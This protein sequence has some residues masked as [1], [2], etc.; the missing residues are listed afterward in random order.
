M[1]PLLIVVIL[2]ILGKVSFAQSVYEVK[3]SP[4]NTDSSSL[5]IVMQGDGT[6][7]IRS[8]K[9]FVLANNVAELSLQQFLPISNPDLPDDSLLYFKPTAPIRVSN[10]NS[11]LSNDLLLCF[12]TDGV[13]LPYPIGIITDSEILKKLNSDEMV[14]RIKID[15]FTSVNNID[16]KEPKPELFLKYF[17]PTDNFFVQLF[18]NNSK[19]IT[20]QQQ[21]TNLFLL[22]VAN[23]NDK[24]I[25]VSAA[26]DMN[27]Y[28]N[29]FKQLTSFLGIKFTPIT[30]S[31]SEYNKQNLIN[32]INNKLTP[33]AQDIVIFYFTGHG[34]RLPRDNRRYPY[35]DLRPNMKSSYMTESL[36]MQ[37]IYEMIVAKKARLNIVISDCCNTHVE[38]TNATAATVPTTKNINLNWSFANC[39]ELFLNP[40]PTS[41]LVTSADA[42]QKA[43]SNDRLGGF[44]G[45]YF[46]SALNSHLNI[47]QKFPSWNA[48]LAS[49]RKQTSYKASRTYCSKPYVKSNICYQVPIFTT[50]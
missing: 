18:K 14:P 41:I 24:E 25:G 9:E 30:I 28:L 45:Y 32:S 29:Y 19:N 40:K 23:T 27:S 6:G 12:K 35:I 48:V 22:I 10:G 31:G 36:N 3:I 50:K 17:L 21:S 11:V 7:F 34:F 13:G 2:F 1:K 44:F 39:K 49:A 38:S 16:I 47:F 37:N 5:L 46:Q 42:D 8:K 33:T 20:S 4:S 26:L 43:T 15:L